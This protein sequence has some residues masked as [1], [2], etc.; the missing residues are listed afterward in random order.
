VSTWLDYGPGLPLTDKP[1]M[2][3]SG[4]SRPLTLADCRPD[5]PTISWDAWRAS[6]PR[7]AFVNPDD[8]I[9]L[10]LAEERERMA[11]EQRR[12]ELQRKRKRSA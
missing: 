10:R 9:A 3:T 8:I 7:E 12:A 6:L 11:A 5:H 1:T 2:R 4:R